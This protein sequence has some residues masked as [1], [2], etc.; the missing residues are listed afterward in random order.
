MRKGLGGIGIVLGIAFVAII[1]VFGYKFGK[2]VILT[3]GQGTFQHLI[4]G[5]RSDAPLFTGK[6]ARISVDL[7]IFKKS[8]FDEMNDI[9]PLSAYFSAGVYASGKY[10]GY[11]R[12][13]GIRDPMG[14]GDALVYV[15]ATR[16]RKMY[17]LHETDQA[18]T[19]F[20]ETDWRNPFNVVDK[21]KISETV[22]LPSE[23]PKTI[24]L[25]N[26]FA[27]Y[28]TTIVTENVKS[29]AISKEGYEVYENIIRTDFS[30]YEPLSVQGL[31]LTLYGV[32]NPSVQIPAEWE[33]DARVQAELRA[34]YIKG[35]T[36]VIALDSS[37]LP[38][39]Y[40]LTRAPEIKTY[41]NAFKKY[42]DAS[43]L[44]EKER[45][46][47]ENKEIQDLPEY[48]MMPSLPNLR[49]AGSDVK[50]AGERFNTYDIAVP[51][52]CGVDVDTPIVQNISESELI[53]FGTVFGQELFTLKD[54]EH[55]FYK[56]AY[57]NKMLMSKEEF[58]VINK[59]MKK[60]SYE[61]YVTKHP[62]F[63][64]KDF[65]GRWTAV[66]EYDYKM[67]G[68][69]GK[70]VLYL[71][72]ERS[73]NVTVSFAKPMELTRT[74]PLY[75]ADWYVLANPDGTLTDLKSEQT[76]CSIYDIPVHGS[77]YAKIACMN[78]QYPYLYWAGNRVG[79][80]YPFNP[81]IGWIVASGDMETFLNTTLDSIGFTSQEKEDFLSYWVPVMRE[82]DAP[83]YHI[84]FLQT[85]DMN[86]F[87]PM[88]IRPTP[89]RYYRVFLDWKPLSAPPA[90]PVAPQQLDPIIRKGF[91]V[92]EWGGLKQ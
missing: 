63:F 4:P 83:W 75:R 91:T 62:L 30:S 13:I 42:E 70:P 77:E 48:P 8:E 89:D 3:A 40:T 53:L 82:K 15:F 9:T 90:T 44:Y 80:S 22:E 41:E 67:I 33:E 49:F 55:P 57:R 45:I 79:M 85:S 7:Q 86:M 69:C 29:G 73:T 5:S 92:I 1:S 88:D 21:T 2:D 32:V 46:R 27:L 87:I 47:F 66:G 51:Y 74:I 64:F 34:K 76:D 26:A 14:P 72:P 11:E 19:L 17:V 43:R 18:S 71:Y 39:N 58:D 65:W 20:A 28:K 60:L 59:D 24:A 84:R 6:L 16:D 50:A 78:N 35:T 68:G 38:Y 12:I 31:P 52:I 36:R 56:F 10:K 23:H 81:H 25:S 37:G 61:E 54:P